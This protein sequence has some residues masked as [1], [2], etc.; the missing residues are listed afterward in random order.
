MS[1]RKRLSTEPVTVTIESLSH[2]G[3]GVTH[4]AGKTV[5]VDGGLSGE[6]VVIQ[7]TRQHSRYSEAKILEILQSAPDR[8]NAKCEHYGVCGGCSF[9]HVKPDYQIRH[10]QD[11]MLE[12]LRHIGGVQP[13]IILS[14]LTGPVWGYRRR[15]RL[16]AKYVEKKQKLLVGFREKNSSFIAD[17]RQCEVLHPSVGF[18]MEDLQKLVS[19]LSVYRQLPQV[20]VAVADNVTV[21]VF[22]HLA[23]L[24]KSDIGLLKNF[25]ID[26]NIN[27][28]L[29]PGGL[30]SIH[31]LTPERAV[32]LFYWLPDQQIKFNFLP[33]DFI[34]VN[35][36]INNE[37]IT[38]TLALLEL[39]GQDNVLDLFC[40]LGNFSL[41][42]ARLCR[43]VTGTEGDAGLI[44]RARANAECNKISNVEFHV[45]DLAD[46]D[47]QANFINREYSK[48]LLD[49][50][51]VGAMKIINRMDFHGTTHLV[52]ISCSP[53]TL[54]RDAGI[55][56]KNKGFELQ[57]AG[58]M[59]MFPHTSHIESI[60]LFVR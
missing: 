30:E 26:K 38:R 43:H 2:E 58:V 52:Y 49:P 22:R 59:D 17:I 40:G 21:L 28:Y 4:V 11:T 39:S 56:V 15:A 32:D 47:I 36:H 33:V 42:M 1:R 6:E 27:I 19:R 51:R 53:A 50:P 57:Q 8:V 44:E 41:P 10:K 35:Q 23:D 25:E 37:M 31:P 5:F 9:Q 18:M 13:K 29:Q 7:Y 45:S 24:N 60:A 46:D 54:A 34:Q 48:V 16:G 55:L 12:Q 3:R 20:E 14:P